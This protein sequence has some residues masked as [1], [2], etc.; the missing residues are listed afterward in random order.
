MSVIGADR[1]MRKLARLPKSVKDGLD[2]A[3][4][5]SGSELINLAKVLINVD[6]GAS[7][8]DIKGTVQA[9]GGYLCDFGQ[10][11]KVIEENHPFVNPA[12]AVT[13]KK[14]KARAKR[15]VNK[16]VKA[17]FNG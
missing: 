1:I 2:A 14:H 6:T 9:D 10:K 13:K 5:K 16:A 7:R 11:S 17:V 4:A 3:T 8:G 12:L 15:A